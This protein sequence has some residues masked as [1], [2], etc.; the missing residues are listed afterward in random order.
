M[1]PLPSE[2]RSIF[3]RAILN[4]REAAENAARAALT[5]LA[6][7]KDKP[8]TTMNDA[9]RELRNALHARARQLGNGRQQVG[10]ET[11][12]EEVAYKQ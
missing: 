5:A 2:L 3:E 1:V 11:L 7:G 6:V 9:Q 8:F 10:I 4:A 12:V